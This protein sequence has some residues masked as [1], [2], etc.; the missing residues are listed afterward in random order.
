MP[1]QLIASHEGLDNKTLMEWSGWA[2]TDCVAAMNCP[3]CGARYG[4]DCRT[5]KGRKTWPPHQGRGLALHSTGYNAN[6][7]TPSKEQVAALKFLYG[8]G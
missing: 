4:N 8:R 2:W 6:V 5:P 3:K 7:Y 1:K